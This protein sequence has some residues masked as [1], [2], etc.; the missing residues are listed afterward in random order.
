MRTQVKGLSENVTK[1]LTFQLNFEPSGYGIWEIHGRT[2]KMK[3]GQV[4][5]GCVSTLTESFVKVVSE[6]QVGQK[7]WQTMVWEQLEKAR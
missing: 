2:W 7:F 4:R 5:A 3:T 6:C 1:E